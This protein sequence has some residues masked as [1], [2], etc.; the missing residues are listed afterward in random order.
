M[1]NEEAKTA[2]DRSIGHALD[3]T[4]QERLEAL[5]TY[6]IV[7][8]LP[9]TAFDDIAR[10]AARTCNAPIALVS[11]LGEHSQW[12]KSEVGLGIKETPREISFCA[13]AIL[14]KG[15]FVVPDATADARFFCNPLVTG[16]LHARFYAGAVLRT[17]NGIPLGTVCVLDRIAR[18]EGLTA[19][20]AETLEALA[21][22]VMR[23]L[24]FRVERRFFQ[25]ALGTMDQGLLMIDADGRVP[26]INTRA[27]ELLELPPEV[28][29]SRPL[30]ADMV[31]FQREQGEFERADA[32]MRHD[33]DNGIVRATRYNYERTRPDGTVLEVRTVPV[34]GG[35]AVRTFTDITTIRAAEAA[36]RYSEERLQHALRASRMIAWER[37]LKT[38]IVSRSE[39]AFE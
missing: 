27:A 6:D 26:I 19:E 24:E 17:A 38:D 20:Q 33:T 4:E 34:I 13:H 15:L 7:G 5:A 8:S 10:I 30:F 11:F 22:A 2:I 32:D 12:F 1:C 29:D 16:D 21:R 35:G 23:E 36:V 39:N 3:W 9:E 31:K 37:D 28:C 18:P 14:Q 25:V